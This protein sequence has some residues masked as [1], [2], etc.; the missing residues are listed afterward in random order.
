MKAKFLVTGGAG[1]IGSAL[2]W[3][4]NQLGHDAILVSDYLGRGDKFRNLV[5]LRFADYLEAD[6][7][8]S[9]IEQ[10]ASW[11]EPIETIF[12]LGANSATTEQDNRLLIET[13]YRYT[14]TLA[15]WAMARDK[16]FVYASSAA[17]Y[18]D[19]SAGMQDDL[20]SLHSLQPLNMY[21]YSKHLFDLYA[22]RMGWLDRMVG[23]KY[24]NVYGPNENHKGDMMSLVQKAVGQIQQTG[25]L[26]LFKSHHPDYA[27]GEQKRDFLY[28]KDAVAMTAHLAFNAKAHGL[29]NLG[30][31][32]A[33]T[34]RALAEAIFAAMA[35]PEAITFIPMPESLREKY[36][37]H[38][39]ADITRLRDAG[40]GKAIT[41]LPDAI[42]DYVRNYVLPGKHLGQ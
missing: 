4:L 37:Y 21:G 24:F 26:K 6:Q 33:N 41:S 42:M 15:H 34:W 36:Q 27:D 10:E 35:C 2:I 39:C 40:Y 5:P 28:V 1:F 19:G 31:G 38:T 23:L 25:Q 22:Q 3:H 18:G 7:L 13:N 17:T 14:K 8:L 9:A 29:Y 11:L 16:R 20:A 32:V 12:H 30:S